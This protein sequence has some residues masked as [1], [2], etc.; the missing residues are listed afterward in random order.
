MTSETIITERIKYFQIE[1]P[2]GVPLNILKLDLDLSVEEL[3]THLLSLEEHGILFI[4]NEEYVKMVEIIGEE[5][6]NKSDVTSLELINEE[7]ISEEPAIKKAETYDLTDKEI[8]ALKIIKNLTDESGHIPRYMM[9]G[10]LLYGDLKM[11]TL[12]VYNIIMS[13]ENKGIIKKIQIKDNEY[14]SI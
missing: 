2:D 6:S 1:Y 3:Q 7:Y 12:G 14:Y 8:S 9:E 11:N 4:E 5:D 10:S 13:L